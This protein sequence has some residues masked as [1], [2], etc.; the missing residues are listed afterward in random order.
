MKFDKNQMK[1]LANKIKVMFIR[2]TI[3][4]LIRKLIGLA[5]NYKRA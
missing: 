3:F 4:E 2:F 5:L 1:R